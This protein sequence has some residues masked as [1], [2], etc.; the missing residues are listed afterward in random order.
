MTQPPDERDPNAADGQPTAGQPPGG[1][2]PTQAWAPPPPDATPPPNATPPPPPPTDAGQPPPAASPIMPAAPAPGSEPAVA[3]SPP[4]QVPA[5][6]APAPGLT[7]ADT[8]SRFVAYVIDL[9]LIGFLSGI[10]VSVLGI[11][12]SLST[13]SQAAA[14]QT[15]QAFYALNAAIGGVY[16]ILW[17]SG[18]RRA[19]LGQRL[20]SIQVGNA[21]DGQALT[22]TQAVKRW[23]GLGGFLGLFSIV[24]SAAVLGAV[25]LLELVWAIVLLIS[26]A[27]SSTKQGLHDRFANSAVVRPAGAGTGVAMAC[28]VIVIGLFLLA[29]LS[30]VAL[31]FLGGQVSSILSDIGNSV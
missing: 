17:W 19:T 18:G 22:T 12:Q 20:L 2:A 9:F 4:P 23:I 27:T 6:D 13:T 26:T 15:S 8:P 11:G 24:P 25:N 21:F 3:W 1:E 28:L 31:I 7:W 30:I 29:I 10:V 5:V 16:F 14:T